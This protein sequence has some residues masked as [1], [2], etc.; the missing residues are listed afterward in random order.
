MI[1]P[2]PKHKKK[3]KKHGKSIFPQAAGTCYLCMR[4]GDYSRKYTEVHHIFDGPN[5]H[6]SE[7]Q[8]L[9]VRLCLKHHREGKDAVH[10][11]AGNM[12]I[13]Q[14]DAQEKYEQTHSREEFMSLIGKNYLD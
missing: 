6:I 10:N 7:E 8:G 13:L 12:R 9:T 1:Y 14:R 3:R 4:Q 11:N 2:K 5:R